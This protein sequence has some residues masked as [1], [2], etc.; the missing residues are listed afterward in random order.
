M[1]WIGLIV[2]LIFSAGFLLKMSVIWSVG[3]CPHGGGGVATL[4]FVIFYPVF[5]TFGIATIL[6]SI[7]VV[8]YRYFVLVLYVGLLALTVF[9]HWL[10]DRL[11]ARELQRQRDAEA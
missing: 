4:D 5:L 8:P 3:R 7:D 2:T 11:G 10:F 6:A 1:F 9:V